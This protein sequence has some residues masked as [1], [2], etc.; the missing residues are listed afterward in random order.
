M[1]IGLF[2]GTFNPIHHGHLIIAESAR[3]YFRLDKVILI[4]SGK[5]PHK[6]GIPIASKEHRL[7]MVMIAI[8]DNPYFSASDY[9]LQKTD[10]TY[11][12]DTIQYF[13]NLYPKDE[14]YFIMGLELLL[15]IDTWKKGE[16]IL[17][18]CKFLV[19]LKPNFSVARIPDKVKNKV[20]F[21]HIPFIDISSTL[22]RGYLS[23]NV[24]LRYLTPET[25]R[26]YISKNKLYQE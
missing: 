5:P 25:V 6:P 23:R 18:E 22:L 9:E 10:L 16:H 14:L 12:F 4:P 15:E 21:F 17:D 20:K 3:S 19:G 13:K 7:K 24:S 26:K 11:T 1:K 8:E 2:G